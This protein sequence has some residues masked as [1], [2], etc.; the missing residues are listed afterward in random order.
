MTLE[1]FRKKRSAGKREA[2][3]AAASES[4]LKEGFARTS[5]ETVSRNA[6][7]S[8]ATLYRQFTSKEDLFD[9]VVTET[10][11]Q[12]ALSEG[13][14]EK[15]KVSL[16]TLA[17][18]YAS[19]LSQPET[20]GMFRMVVAECGRDAALADRF[21]KAVK[22]RLSD[23]FVD[24]IAREALAGKVKRLSAQDHVAGQLQGM[25][26]H[27][28]LLRGLIMGDEIETLAEAEHI[29]DEALKTWLARWGS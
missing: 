27:S 5:M 17:R 21:Y 19:L 18:A 3:L 13:P 2:I 24:A 25:I 11:D 4:F 6:R 14:N 26:E 1:Q 12:L 20:R 7:V 29:A 8:T 16:R 22:S 28:T 15:A 10:M 9:A 23:L